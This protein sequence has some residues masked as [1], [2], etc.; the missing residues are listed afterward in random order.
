MQQQ[1]VMGADSVVTNSQ[2]GLHEQ[3]KPERVQEELQSMPGWT[4]SPERQ[5]INR[6]QELPDMRVALAFATFALE[7]AKAEGQ[8]M[9]VLIA[10]RLV[11]LTLTGAPV[12]GTRGGLTLAALALAKRLG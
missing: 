4:F 10:D 11:G 6:L 1:S 5:A 8:P 12:N 3:L 7:L 2:E 9:S